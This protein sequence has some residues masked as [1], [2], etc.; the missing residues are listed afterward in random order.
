MRK[1]R[2]EEV[3]FFF[4]CLGKGCFLYVERR[5]ISP[6][7]EEKSF[8]GH[9][10]LWWRKIQTGVFPILCRKG[11]STQFVFFSSCLPPLEDGYPLYSLRRMRENWEVK[12][13]APPFTHLIKVPFLI[14]H[15][16]FARKIQNK[17]K[18]YRRVGLFPTTSIWQLIEVFCLLEF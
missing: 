14:S 16:L 15:S 2:K 18:R 5:N 6:S 13:T 10:F 17:T 3:F 7:F 12:C 11:T 8:K 1:N 9:K 4:F